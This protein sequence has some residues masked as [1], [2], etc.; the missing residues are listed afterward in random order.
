MDWAELGHLNSG[1]QTIPT[2]TVIPTNGKLN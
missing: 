2:A 1:P